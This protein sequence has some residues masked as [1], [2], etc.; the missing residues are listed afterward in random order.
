LKFIFIFFIRVYQWVISPLFPPSCR[1]NP[2]CS[3]YAIEAITNFGIFKGGFL[4]IKRIG[5]CHPWGD[6]GH[7]PVPKKEK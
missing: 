7:D 4:A 1:F 5:K 2:T 3:S 6:Q